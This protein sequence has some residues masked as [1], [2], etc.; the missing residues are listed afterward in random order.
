ME[1]VIRAQRR[2]G[3]HPHTV[4]KEDLCC[5]VN[6]SSSFQE[7]TP[8]HVDIV[9]QTINST[10]QCQGTEEKDEHDK[11]GEESCE[12][13]DLARGVETLGDDQ[14]DADP[15]NEQAAQQLPLNTP[16]AMLQSLILHQNTVAGQTKR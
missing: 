16:Q 4:G 3:T 12:P 7:L 9:R 10:L 11:V 6:P 15:G 1:L 14:V 8:V 5:S 2:Q 13:D